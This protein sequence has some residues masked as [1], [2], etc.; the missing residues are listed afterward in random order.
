MT[1]DNASQMTE[2]EVLHQY[3]GERIANGGRE[4]PVKKVLA[5]F[6]LYCQ[7]LDKMRELLREARDSSARGESGPLDLDALLKR[8]ERRWDEK[9][10]PE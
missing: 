8:V 10:I 5:D 1:T 3:L 2:V 7:E 9:G 4:A 6:Q